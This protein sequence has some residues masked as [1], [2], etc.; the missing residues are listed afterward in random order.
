MLSNNYIISNSIS[1]ISTMSQENIKTQISEIL[2][3]PKYLYLN[4]S[5]LSV[6][7]YLFSELH[8]ISSLCQL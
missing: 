3:I 2:L 7:V 4:N 5:Y 1:Y 8:I 6:T